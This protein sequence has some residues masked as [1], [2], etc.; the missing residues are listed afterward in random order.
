MH[1]AIHFFL[2]TEMVALVLATGTTIV[3][4]FFTGKYLVFRKQ[5]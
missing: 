4:S 5:V 1:T 3:W 2:L